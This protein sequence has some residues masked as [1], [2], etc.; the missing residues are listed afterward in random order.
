MEDTRSSHL[1]RMDILIT[2]GIYLL[3]GAFVLGLTG[4]VLVA[5]ITFVEDVRLLFGAGSDN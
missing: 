3:Q 4:S 2:A 1:E 5:A